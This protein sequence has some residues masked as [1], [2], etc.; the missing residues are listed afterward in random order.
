MTGILSHEMDRDAYRFLVQGRDDWETFFFHWR[1][2]DSRASVGLSFAMPQAPCFHLGLLRLLRA[3]S[4][5]S[6]GVDANTLE[7]ARQLPIPD[8]V[9]Q[10]QDALRSKFQRCLDK[11]DAAKLKVMYSRVQDDEV[12]RAY[13]LQSVYEPAM[14]FAPK[15]RKGVHKPGQNT[16]K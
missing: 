13:L 3:S 9:S 4:T 5:R 6:A 16:T 8:D 2:G 1:Q 11:S 7:L 12:K 15:K 14:K 10:K